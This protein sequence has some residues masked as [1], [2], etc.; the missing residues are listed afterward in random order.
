MSEA[1]VSGGE[2]E[3]DETTEDKINRTHGDARKMLTNASYFAFTATPKNKTL[4]MFGEPCRR[5]RGQG[6][7]PALPQL[8]D[9]AG[10]PGGLHP[11]RAE[12]LTRR[13]TAITS[14]SRRSRTI[15][16]FDT[17]KAQEE[18]A[19]LRREP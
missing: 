2:E 15:P 7:A 4:E 19:P 12:E 9:E 5:W 10:H 18:A 3:D 13:S 16:E 14:W 11:G 6:Q 1:L 17:K 8:H